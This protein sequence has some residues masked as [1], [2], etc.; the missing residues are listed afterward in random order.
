[1]DYEG[2]FWY[3]FLVL[4]PLILLPCGVSAMKRLPDKE[5][6]I[7]LTGISGGLS[8]IS[9][10]AMLLGV[11]QPNAFDEDLAVQYMEASSTA[12]CYRHPDNV[13]WLQ[14]WDK[15]EVRFPYGIRRK[16]LRWIEEQAERVRL[17]K[18]HDTILGAGNGTN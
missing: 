4:I 16:S 15:G 8:L 13:N 2:V 17:Q 3:E 6:P 10:V 7:A 11:L 18:I 9:I 5:W 12:T 14:I 1:M